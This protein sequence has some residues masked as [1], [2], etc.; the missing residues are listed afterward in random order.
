MLAPMR[1]SGKACA[2]TLVALFF[3]LSGLPE[4]HAD[5]L[6]EVEQ[7]LHISNAGDRFEARAN[8]QAKRLIYQY[9]VIVRRNT[10]YRLPGSLERRIAACYADQYRWENFAP[11]IARILAANLSDQELQILIDFHRNLGLPPSA[12]EVFRRTAAKADLI[13][14]L[15][16][17]Y[18]FSQSRGC[19]EQDVQLILDHLQANE[20]TLLPIP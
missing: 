4:V 6:E 3:L 5:K 9:S 2:A 11:G 18:I 7:L 14:E 15:S 13:S 20:I 16:A 19:L 10:N 17:D 8:D 1:Q 12:I